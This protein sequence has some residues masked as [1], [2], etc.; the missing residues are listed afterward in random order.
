MFHDLDNKHELKIIYSKRILFEIVRCAFTKLLYFTTSA[1]MTLEFYNRWYT[2]GTTGTVAE[3]ISTL[4]AVFCAMTF[5]YFGVDIE[6]PIS[7]T[8][9]KDGKVDGG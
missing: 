8:K 7:Y 4:G 9:K 3:D 1:Y 5:F 6:L 2:L